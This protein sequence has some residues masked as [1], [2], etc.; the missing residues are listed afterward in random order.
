MGRGVK[1]PMALKDMI[2]R[3]VGSAF[4]RRIDMSKLLA[5]QGAVASAQLRLMERI[6]S[7]ADV[8]FSIF[9]QWGED[10]IVEWIVQQYG[11]LPEKFVEFGVENYRESNTRFLISNRNWKGLIIDGGAENIEF[12]KNDPISFQRDLT[13][14]C[15]FITADNIERIIEDAGFGGEI[16]ILSID[17]DGNDYWIWKVLERVRPHIVI[18]EYNAVFGDV[19]D[20]TVPYDPAFFRTKAHYS[21]LYYGASIG[22]LTRL[23]FE[24]GYTLIG[25]NRAGSNAFFVRNDRAPHFLERIKDRTAKPSRFRESRSQNGELTFVR[26]CERAQVIGDCVVV[27]T[28]SGRQVPLKSFG[29][30]YSAHWLSAIE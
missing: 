11:D 12:V 22:A 6:G 23:G 20:L 1:G 21:N 24:K 28:S 14:K 30:L 26:G 17:I 13:A 7:L 2:R 29:E 4:S 8:E 15:A 18:A 3:V 10:G 9:S 19:F 16:G 5:A 27:E 25:S